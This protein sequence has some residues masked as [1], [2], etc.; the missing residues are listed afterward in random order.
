[1]HEGTRKILVNYVPVADI[2][3]IDPQTFAVVFRRSIVKQGMH[4]MDENILRM[5]MYLELS[6]PRGLVTR[7]KK[8]FERLTLLN[9]AFPLQ[10]CSD[11]IEV[12]QKINFQDR[13]V[14]LEFC[15]NHKRVLVGPEVIELMERRKKATHLNSLVTRGGPVLF[16]STQAQLDADDIADMLEGAVRV[17]SHSSVSDEL[18][19]Y[20][21]I[22]RRNV[23][24]ALIFQETACHAYSVLQLDED[25]EIRVGTPD[26]FLHLYYSLLLFGKK[27]KR[28][29]ETGL[30]CLVQKLYTLSEEGRN[31]PGPLLPSFGLRCSGHQKGYATLLKERLKRQEKEKASQATRKSKKSKLSKKTRR[32]TQ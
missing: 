3:R 6:R 15:A 4:Y 9:H 10:G 25:R 5:M 31:N 29:F 24:L 1:M 2:S 23:P 27:E 22:S 20:V 8:V 26:L 30:Q 28:F 16:M 17:E 7:W 12:N 13:R 14:L 11:P 18:F 32:V 19:S 21:M